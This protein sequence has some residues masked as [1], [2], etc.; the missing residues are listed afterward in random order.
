MVSLLVWIEFSLMIGGAFVFM[1]G[2]LWYR[3]AELLQYFDVS[4]NPKPGFW[5][6]M[7]G[8]AAM[9]LGIGLAYVAR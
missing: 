4:T 8:F 3:G 2:L 5:V 6:A 7:G 1:F 9:L